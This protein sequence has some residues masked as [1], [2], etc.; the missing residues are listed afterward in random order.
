[1]TFFGCRNR[2]C[3]FFWKIISTIGKNIDGSFSV[4][5][6]H[7]L[8]CLNREFTK[9]ENISNIHTWACYKIWNVIFFHCPLLYFL[10]FFFFFCFSLCCCFFCTCRVKATGC[11]SVEKDSRLLSPT[12]R[13][14]NLGDETQKSICLQEFTSLTC[15]TVK[16]APGSPETLRFRV[17]NY[18]MFLNRCWPFCRKCSPPWRQ[19]RWRWSTV[20]F[21]GRAG[22]LWA[23]PSS[24]W[25]RWTWWVWLGMY[26]RW[27]QIKA[28]H[29][30]KS[31]RTAIFRAGNKLDGGVL[32]VIAEGD[33]SKE[34]FGKKKSN[35]R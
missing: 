20:P 34:T 30:H 7:K 21:G 32:W 18:V 35:C 10:F 28:W 14:S 12:H 29:M 19:R 5:Q 23:V 25:E 31:P 4:N 6:L 22:R 27:K 17:L 8:F 24:T 1:M 26:F 9:L 11:Y 16:G 2:R 15:K 33:G 13:L 3:I